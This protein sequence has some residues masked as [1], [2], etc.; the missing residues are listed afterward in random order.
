MPLALQATRAR[1][2]SH[3]ADSEE[4]LVAR[5]QRG[6]NDAF[7]EL[8]DRYSTRLRRTLYRI[9]RDCDA[10]YDAVQEALVRAWQNIDRF[11]GRSRFF[12]W[13]TRIGINEAY[14]GLR[15][16][17]EEPLDVDDMV[18]ERVPGW[19]NQPDRV[20]ESREFLGAVEGALG[21]LPLDYRTAVTLR[22][23]EGLSTAE[24]AEVLGIG[25]RAL[26]SRLHRGRMALRER[27][28][29]Y[30]EEGYL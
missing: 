5:A 11:E 20:F 17:A 30:F 22:D 24:T 23:V 21:K 16:P 7:N 12:T 26:K 1:P 10:A 2:M 25:E 13:L 15:R 3:S 18:G 8:A 19:G 14:R 28:D 4:R 29:H 27:L 6:D 9:T